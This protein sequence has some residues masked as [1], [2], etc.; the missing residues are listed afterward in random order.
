MA[1]PTFFLSQ[2]YKGAQHLPPIGAALQP[3]SRQMAGYVASF[4]VRGQAQVEQ[5]AKA[6]TPLT[7]LLADPGWQFGR[8]KIA[9]QPTT[10]WVRRNP[11]TSRTEWQTFVDDAIAAQRA[12]GA[13]YLVVP[14]VE[15]AGGTGVT[16][17]ARQV[18]AV[19]A[20]F[21]AREASDPAWLARICIHDEWLLQAAQRTNLLDEL[22]DLPDPVGVALH[23]RWGRRAASMDSAS[24]GMLKVVVSRLAADDR[25]VILLSSGMIGW[26][27]TAWGAA[28]WSAGL[29]RSSWSDEGRIPG[30]RARGSRNKGSLSTRYFNGSSGHNMTGCARAQ[31]TVRASALFADNSM[32]ERVGRLLRSSTTSTRLLDSLIPR[33][34]QRLP[35]DGRR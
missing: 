35:A 11:P 18:A 13:D 34:T 32:V 4:D 6:R 26:L 1:T 9:N 7:P 3:R 30:G 25:D 33:L 23:V 17:L 27:A 10:P 14:G 15:M 24:L 31:A 20:A 16:Q 8:P 5:A 21:A 12:I 2:A 19:R 22:S 28:G 29:S